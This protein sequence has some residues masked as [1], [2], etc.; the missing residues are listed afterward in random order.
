[1]T[2]RRLLSW[3]DP[4]GRLSRNAYGRILV[5]LL[6][7]SVAAFCLM[8]AFVGHDLRGLAVVFAACAI[9]FWLASLAQTIRRLHDRN[10]SGRWLALGLVLYGATFAP[11]DK[12]ADTYPIPVVLFTLGIVVFFVWLLIETISLQGTA[13]PNRYG[14]D[15]AA[16]RAPAWP[17]PAPTELPTTEP[18]KPDPMRGLP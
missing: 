9:V 18:P 8:I 11:V 16:E 1:M 12:V 10:R 3:F 15:P 4:R 2:W 13:G 7:L 5:R 17:D 6:L 14:D